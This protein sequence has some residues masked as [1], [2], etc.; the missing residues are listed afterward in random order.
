MN[1]CVVRAIQID[2]RFARET[3]ATNIRQTTRFSHGASRRTGSY[4][5]SQMFRSRLFKL[6]EPALTHSQAFPPDSGMRRI[7]PDEAK[8]PQND[9]AAGL[10]VGAPEDAPQVRI[11]RGVGSCAVCAVWRVHRLR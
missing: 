3:N 10:W 6:I 5:G 11:A 9:H 4:D 1:A 8:S 7:R 2:A